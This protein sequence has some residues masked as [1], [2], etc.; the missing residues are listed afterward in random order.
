MKIMQYNKYEPDCIDI[1][2]GTNGGCFSWASNT[3]D[4]DGDGEAGEG[5][6]I[7]FFIGVFFLFIFE[8]LQ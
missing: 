6:D 7:D 1:D 5:E 2:G 4:D 3:D 8:M